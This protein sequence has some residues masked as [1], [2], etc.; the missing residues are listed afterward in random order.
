MTETYLERP[1]CVNC[2]L[3][4]LVVGEVLVHDVERL[5]VNFE[6]VMLLEVVDGDHATS[7]LDKES[8]LV[9]ATWTLRLLVH[10][11]D[12]EDVV[13]AIERDLD[14]LVVHHSQQIAKGLDA[15]LGNEIADDRGL[16]Q[17]TGGRVRNS[18]AC[19]LTGLEVGVSED[20]DEWWESADFVACTSRG[21]VHK[22]FPF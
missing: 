21:S 22:H 17:A 2:G 12:L 15:S 18:P 8:I 20:V 11:A 3:G 5:L 10:L 7:L 14:D 6:V 4:F 1:C 16:L 9:D 13:E 19:L